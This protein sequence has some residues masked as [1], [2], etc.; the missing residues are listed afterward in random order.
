M[1]KD[2]EQLKEQLKQ[3]E[4]LAALGLLSAGI[5]HEIQNPL[6]FVINFSKMSD[7]LLKDL[8]EIVEDNQA[9]IPA[10]DL[11]EIT[12]IVTDLK[13]NMARIV[14]HGERAV[15]IIQNILLMSRG[16]Q[17]E[18]MVSDICHIVKE[19]LWLAYHS[20]RANYKNFNVS[21]H[22]SY[23]EAMPK[24]KV[25]PQDLSRAVLN[26]VNNAFYAVWEKSQDDSDGYTPEVTVSVGMSDGNVI[27]RMQDNGTGMDDEVK[28]HIFDNFYTTK[29]IGKGTGLGMGITKSIIEDK[30]GGRLTFDS[31]KGVGSS[32][33]F[34]IP[35]RK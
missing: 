32:F 15:S 13:E 35:I 7:Q 1:E 25:I 27:I 21:I 26:V 12:E 22:E 16:K 8:V 11:D 9:H 17:D 28:Q 6:N 20:M 18:Y 19:N 33:T 24:A 3:Q 34:V 14:E 5:V 29:P 23:D 30:H 10:D 31:T 4:K 2:V